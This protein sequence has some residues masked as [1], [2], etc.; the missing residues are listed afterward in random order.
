L[1]GA[2]FYYFYTLYFSRENMGIDVSDEA[3]SVAVVARL[4]RVE[5]EREREESRE[6]V[7]FV[8]FSG[9]VCSFTG[10]WG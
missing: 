7:P 9:A 1:D 6:H 5:R 10:T 3:F 8:P 4:R 2:Y